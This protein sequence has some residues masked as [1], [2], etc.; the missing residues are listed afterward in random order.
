MDWVVLWICAEVIMCRRRMTMAILFF[1]ISRISLLYME[2]GQV[3]LLF[4]LSISQAGYREFTMWR[5]GERVAAT[6][7]FIFDLSVLLNGRE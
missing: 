2:F 5:C 7:R 6:C 4:G 1:K 3:V